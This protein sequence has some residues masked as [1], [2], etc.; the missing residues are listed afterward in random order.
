VL[1]CVH[2]VLSGLNAKHAVPHKCI[3]WLLL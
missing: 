2:L 3:I 1:N